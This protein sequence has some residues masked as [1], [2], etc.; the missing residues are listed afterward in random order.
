MSTTFKPTSV[1]VILAVA[2]SLLSG[3]AGLRLQ[4]PSVTLVSLKVVEASLF[5]QRFTFKLRVQNPNDRD[6]P[7]T[8]MSFEVN[9]NDRPFAKGVSNKPVILPRLGEALVEVTA[10]SDLSGI[11]RQI[12]ELSKGQLTSLSYHI[13]GRLVTA[14]FPDLSFENSGLIDMPA[15]GQDR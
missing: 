7:I 11:I 14:S 12:N 9:L 13:K 1:I 15:S 10:V 5:E 3:C 4:P 8:G 6:I 2:L